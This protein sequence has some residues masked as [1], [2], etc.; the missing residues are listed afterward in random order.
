MV[1]ASRF[2]SLEKLAIL[3][4]SQVR[5]CGVEVRTDLGQ[6]IG[7]VPLY[8]GWLE[9]GDGEKVRIWDV[10]RGGRELESRSD[11]GAFEPW[12]YRIDPM[13]LDG[14]ARSTGTENV[15]YPD[16]QATSSCS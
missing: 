16:Q 10:C 3:S 9:W 1:A 15:R 13:I 6:A 12:S 11:S 8:L 4:E 14:V 5:D 2:P 7:P